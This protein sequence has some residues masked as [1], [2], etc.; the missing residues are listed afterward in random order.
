M[1][2]VSFIMKKTTQC[3]DFWREKIIIKVKI[4]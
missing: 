1:K 2:I 4:F 3:I